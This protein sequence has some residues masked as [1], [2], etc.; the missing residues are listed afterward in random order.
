MSNNLDTAPAS[1]Y[2]YLLT[3]AWAGG[4]ASAK[5]AA[6]DKTYDVFSAV[7]GI[8]IDFGTQTGGVEDVPVK[9][10]MP[11]LDPVAT[12]LVGYPFSN[13]TVLIE[14]IDPT[15]S[16]TRRKCF[17]GTVKQAVGNKNGNAN[18]CE[19]TVAGLKDFLDNPLGI[20]ANNTCA[21]QFN[22]SNCAL[23]DD[24]L[25]AYNAA[26][27]SITLSTIVGNL[28]NFSG[29][30]L[31]A[32]TY[33]RGSINYLGLSLMIRSQVSTTQVEVF[34]A[35]PP[36][37]AGQL[38]TIVPGCRKTLADCIKWMNLKNFG[39]F[40]IGIPAFHPSVDTQ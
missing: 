22:D 10:L 9:I 30:T 12:M 19:V 7:A 32:D 3:F 38:V 36:S 25:A 16:G 17:Y 33:N 11:V 13:C 2:I 27:V 39:G 18:L 20:T 35:P 28:V 31:T 4:T 8:S 37:W 40:G 1:Q 14:E 5:Y 26:K 34:N 21:W 15:N 29:A 24:G 23:S 6:S